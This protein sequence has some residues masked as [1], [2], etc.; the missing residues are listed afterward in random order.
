MTTDRKIIHVVA[1]VIENTE[2]QILIA[3]R[4]QH[5]HQGGLWE[6]PGGKVESGESA[7]HALQRELHEELNINISD[8]QPLIQ[9][10]HNYPDKS[11]FLD[12]QHI[13]SFSGIAIGNEGQKIQW[14]NKSEL[15]GFQFPAANKPIIDATQLPREYLITPEHELKDREQFLTQLEMQLQSGIRLVQLRAKSLSANE[16][17]TL[18]A[19][20]NKLTEASGARLQVNTSVENAL[21]LGASGIH[22]SSRELFKTTSFPKD[23]YVSASCHNQKEINQAEQLGVNFIV[24]SPVK[25]THSHPDSEPIGWNKF[26]LFCEKT[27]VPVFALGGMERDDTAKAVS[28]GAQGIAAISGLFLG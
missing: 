10:H 5:V 26:E 28:C 27:T 18:Y 17:S 3:K 2:G 15:N 23:L 9:I 22:L 19:Q 4:P 13:T 6:F 24:L 8:S 1:A 7:N 12:V 20:V 21:R 11:V 25:F 16:F 14:V